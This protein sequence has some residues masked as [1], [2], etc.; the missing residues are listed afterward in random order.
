MENLRL[1]T[2]AVIFWATFA[3]FLPHAR[4]DEYDDSQ[5]NPLR[6]V[7]YLVYPAGVLLEWTVFRPLHFLVSSTPQ[8]EYVFGHTPHP[9]IFAEPQPLY[10][11]GTPKKVPL[12]QPQAP[13]AMAP[14]EPVAEIVTV[15]EVPVEKTVVKEVPKVVEVEKVVFPDIAFRFDSSQLTELGKGEVYLAAQKFKEKSDILIV[16]EGNT[17]YVG[18]AEYNGKLGL[19]RAETVR[20]EL[21]R[22]GVDPERMSVVSFGE[23]KPLIAQQTDWARAVNRRVEFEVKTP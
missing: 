21:V 7:A 14:Q 1:F 4:A 18:T 23:S 5:S 16:I 10:D 8:A 12:P 11:F 6:V 19:R 20:K 2:V 13:K 3:S 9:A 22:L 15:K 17:D